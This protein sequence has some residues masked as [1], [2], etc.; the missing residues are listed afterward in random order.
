MP[1]EQNAVLGDKFPRSRTSHQFAPVSRAIIA[2]VVQKIAAGLWDG[3]CRRGCF[4]R[5][6][7]PGLAN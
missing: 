5:R 2:D 3:A 6:R 7:L 1:I 4:A